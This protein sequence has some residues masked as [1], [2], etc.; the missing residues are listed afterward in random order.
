MFVRVKLTSLVHKRSHK[1]L[2]KKF[3]KNGGNLLKKKL[4]AQA[5]WSEDLEKIAQNFE[6]VAK[7][8]AETKIFQNIFIKVQFKA[9]NIL[10]KSF[11]MLKMHTTNQILPLISSQKLWNFAQSGHP[12]RKPSCKKRMRPTVY[13]IVFSDDLTL[14]NF[15]VQLLKN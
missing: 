1:L 12:E 14:T 8:V 3:C 5:G 9:Q 11:W 13:R 15:L 7:T 2:C 6:K 4:W 10:K